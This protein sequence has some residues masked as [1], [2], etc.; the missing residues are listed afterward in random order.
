MATRQSSAAP[1]LHRMRW[2][3]WLATAALSL[4]SPFT[5]A[6][7]RQ[8]GPLAPLGDQ[9]LRAIVVH[10]AAGAEVTLTSR[11]DLQ[12]VAAQLTDLKAHRDLKVNPEFNL[13][14]YPQ[15]GSTL[16]LR[17]GQILIGPDIPASAYAKRWQLKDRALYEFISAKL[18]PATAP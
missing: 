18:H 2:A 17:L 8:A 6:A 4:A 9:A 10:D 1:W 3:G 12:F 16:R 14:F 5:S 13:D 7:A 11:E 15:Q